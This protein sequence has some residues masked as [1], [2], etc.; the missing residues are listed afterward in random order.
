MRILY[1]ARHNQPFGNDDEGSIAFALRKLGHEVDCVPETDGSPA[2]RFDLLNRYGAN[3]HDLC[4]FHKWNDLEAMKKLHYP[5]VFWYFDL[6]D[7]NDPSLIGRCKTRRDWMASVMPMADL[8]FCTDGDWVD[9][10]PIKLVWL[11]QGADERVM[12]RYEKVGHGAPRSILF[13]GSHQRCG[14]GRESFVNEMKQTYRHQFTHTV[15][16]A[17]RTALMELIGRTKVVVAP[18]HPV[19]DQYWSNRVYVSLGFGAFMIHPY[20]EGL[21]RHYTNGID[22][23]MYADREELHDLIK[24]ALND[25]AWRNR[26]SDAG[27]RRTLKEH[28][29]THRVRSLLDTVQNRLGVR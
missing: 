29:Y 16:G 20:C 26:V 4:L 5:K 17:Y 24:R 19:T 10:H 11:M 28:T 18:D 25:E 14:N 12:G 21:K 9:R 13:T 8:G 1:V 3:E 7:Y 22:L 23:E 15:S 2:Q 6:V 27:F